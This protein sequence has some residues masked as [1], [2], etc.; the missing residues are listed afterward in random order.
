MSKKF[1]L[2]IARFNGGKK[3]SAVLKGI[4][5]HVYVSNYCHM[6]NC[7]HALTKEVLEL[8]L[9]VVDVQTQREFVGCGNANGRNI[10]LYRQIG[11]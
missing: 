3:N 7:E 1:H 9:D 6:E 4:L 11:D 2:S 10:E 5:L 8:C